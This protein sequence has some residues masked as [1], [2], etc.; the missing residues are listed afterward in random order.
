[1]RPFQTTARQYRQ[2]SLLLAL[3]G[4]LAL[5][6]A[7]LSVHTV[8]PGHELARLGQGL[9]TPDFLN[10]PDIWA[11][12][13]NTLAFAF[14]GV[15]LGVAGGLLLALGWHWRPVRAASAVVRAV[16]ELFWGLLFHWTRSLWPGMISHAVW[17]V[18]VFLLLPIAQ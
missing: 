9:L 14:Q 8:T 7:D 12:L 5:G 6:L 3:A 2:V 16:H 15:A 18:T 10:T 13:A 17:D 11:A 1:M 4:L